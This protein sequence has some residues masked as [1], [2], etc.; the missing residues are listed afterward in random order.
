MWPPSSGGRR[1]DTYGIIF[2]FDGTLARMFI[3]FD[4]M[5]RVVNGIFARHGVPPGSLE[6]RFILERIDEAFER[7]VVKNPTLARKVREEA[8]A[9]IE[10]MEMMA[11][12]RSHL[13]PGVYRRLWSLWQ[14]GVR[15]AIVTRNCEQALKRV[16]GKASLF[17]EIILTRENSLAYKPERRAIDPVLAAFALPAGNIFMVG[18]HPIDI[19]TARAA[20]LH[21]VAV[22]TGTGRKETLIE[23]G[24]A[25]LFKHVNQALDILFGLPRGPGISQRFFL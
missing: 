13:L 12:A 18:D 23:A 21:P 9:A 17:F 22:L 4:E 6:R 2:D 3:D 15:M 25:H 7:T 8:F 19:L 20:R 5:R 10:E 16:I 1:L 14:R 24:A 11:A